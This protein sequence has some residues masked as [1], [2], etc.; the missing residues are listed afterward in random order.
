MLHKVIYFKSRHFIAIL[1][2][3]VELMG[4]GP[5]S[6][7]VFPPSPSGM[8]IIVPIQSLLSTILDGSGN[9]LI[10]ELFNFSLEN[11]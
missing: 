5:V 2:M 11:A 3:S 10:N 1:M 9:E 6:I 8:G 7:V 4:F